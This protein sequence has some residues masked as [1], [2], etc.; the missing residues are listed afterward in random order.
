MNII[1]N[2]ALLFALSFTPLSVHAIDYGQEL[3]NAAK[4]DMLKEAEELI[5]YSRANVNAQDTYGRTA[6]MWAAY[7]GYE[8]MV[9]LLLKHKANVNAKSNS[10]QTA[11]VLAA[12]EGHKNIVQLLLEAGADATITNNQG[13]TALD[14]TKIK[15]T[16]IEDP[17]LKK[18][19]KE[20][21]N[22]LSLAQKKQAGMKSA[23]TRELTQRV[24]EPRIAKRI[25]EYA[26]PK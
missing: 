17:Q 3:I 1:K 19:Y 10:G 8:D 21:E 14:L 13:R 2:Y 22:T 24:V 4:A 6:L 5:T 15:S 11:L 26:Q 20:I 16:Q 25:M 12:V 9:K 18:I 7:F 23:L